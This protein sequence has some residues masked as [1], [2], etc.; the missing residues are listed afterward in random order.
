MFVVIMTL[1]EVQVNFGRNL[2]LFSCSRDYYIYLLG[3]DT[4]IIYLSDIS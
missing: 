1:V 3:S 2:H 4:R